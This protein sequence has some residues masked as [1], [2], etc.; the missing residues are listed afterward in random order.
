M[1][2]KSAWTDIKNKYH[3]YST[4]KYNE[5][6][7]IYPTPEAFEEVVAKN[8]YDVFINFL[9]KSFKQSDKII[10]ELFPELRETEIRCKY[11]CFYILKEN[12]SEGDTCIDA[13]VLARLI[14]K[15]FPE[16][17]NYIVPVIKNDEMFHFDET[18]KIVS[19]EETYRNEERIATEIKKRVKHP[20][21]TP[22]NWEKYVAVDGLDLTDEQMQILKLACTESVIMLNGSAGTGKTSA[23][24]ALVEMVTHEGHD[25]TILAPTGIAAK[26]IAEVTGHS[27]STIHRHILS[28]K[29]I[30]DF[31]IIDEMSMVGVGL[32]GWLF[33]SLPEHT[34]IIFVCDESQLASISCGNIVQ[35][36]IDSHIVPTVNL[37]RVFRYGVGGIATVATDVRM[38]KEISADTHFND[39]TFLKASKNPL[40]D[41]TMAYDNL[42]EEYSED[43]IMILSPFNVREAGTYAINKAVQT[44]Y[45]KTETLMSYNRQNVEIEFKVGDRVVNT[46]NNYH[47][48]GE[49][50]EIAIMNGD[51]G[52]VAGVDSYSGNLMVDFNNG[53]A[54]LE[55]AEVFKLL[56]GYSISVHKSQGSQSKA[57]VVIADK[58]HGFFLTRNLL[59][60][61][62][63]RAQEKLI[64]IGDIDTINKALEVEE[65]KERE[66]NLRSMLID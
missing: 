26:R 42:R 38:G 59:Y 13:N 46:E 48:Q 28:R 57:V 10:L 5:I 43:D 21:A 9:N 6:K 44:K 52:I 41:I 64:V 12:E 25:C 60:V 36:I 56:L 8:P 19:L 1:A 11:C 50:D 27:A 37:T 32:L 22:M 63:S 3:I 15:D 61:A 18:T 47:A 33:L 17:Y 49:Y 66:T 34:K 62:L 16:V 65:N 24:K 55:K 45:N 40:K 29:S 39:Y 35:D 14:K 4:R 20:I 30:G 31:L 2:K 51:I 23:M 53:R 54:Y 58:S 7:N